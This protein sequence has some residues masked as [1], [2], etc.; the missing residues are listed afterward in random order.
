MTSRI[1]RILAASASTLLAAVGLTAC[2]SEATLKVCTSVP[3]EPFQYKDS[4]QDNKIVGFDVEMMDML[5]EDLG[6]K[7]EIIEPGFNRITSGES[8]ESGECDIVAAALT[9]TRER[10]EVMDFSQAYYKAD[11]ALAVHP[12]NKT[13]FKKLEDLDGHTIGVQSDTTG[14]EYARLNEKQYSYKIKEFPDVRKLR[15]AVEYENVDAAI[16]DVALWN[17]E[18]QENPG[19]LYVAD[20]YETGEEYGYAVAE[21]NDEMLKDINDLIDRCRKDGTFDD[22]YEEWLADDFEEA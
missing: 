12:D 5:A 8:L 14:A 18:V 6:M 17:I 19:Y 15:E 21:G 10:Q 2:G 16:A 11:Q 13:K 7:Q 4:W 9:I 20:E 1:T 3:F 22:L